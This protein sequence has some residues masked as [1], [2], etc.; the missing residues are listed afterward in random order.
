MGL[1]MLN[2]DAVAELVSTG[3]GH[4]EFGGGFGLCFEDAALV[5][6]WVAKG[7]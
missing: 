7:N 5:A 1:W 4:S 6:S 3:L 2:D